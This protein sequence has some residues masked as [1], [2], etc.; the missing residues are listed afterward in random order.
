MSLVVLTAAATEA[1]VASSAMAVVGDVGGMEVVLL[2]ESPRE[3]P[4]PRPKWQ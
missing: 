3:E 4:G 2:V 1:S